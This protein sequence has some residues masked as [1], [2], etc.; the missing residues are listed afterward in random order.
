MQNRGTETLV[1][2]G[3][4]VTTASGTAP[5]NITT[6][7]PDA[8]QTFTLPLPS[9]SWNS[10]QPLQFDSSVWL[11]SGKT[12]ANPTNNRRVESYSPAKN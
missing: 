5:F 6:L 2:V 3:V 12:D 11:S 4:Q 1:N 9:S 10:D 7:L 8:I